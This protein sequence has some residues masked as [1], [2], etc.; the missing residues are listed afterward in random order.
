MKK[1]II[2]FMLLIIPTIF[3]V[4]QEQSNIQG[5][6]SYSLDLFPGTSISEWKTGQ[7][8]GLDLSWQATKNTSFDSK[9]KLSSNED[10]NQ[11]KPDFFIENLFVSLVP[12][13]W[14][15]L[16][17]GIFQY[18]H[19]TAKLLPVLNNEFSK[20]RWI[21][22]NSSELIKGIFGMKAN[23]IFNDLASLSLVIDPQPSLLQTNASALL[24][25]LLND[26][27]ISIGVSAYNYELL[28]FHKIDDDLKTSSHQEKRLAA[29]LSLSYYHENFGLYGDVIV[30]NG[31]SRQ[32][33]DVSQG[34]IYGSQEQAN[35]W[36]VTTTV[37]FE[38]LLKLKSY[39]SSTLLLEYKF[40]QNTL[41][42]KLYES[43]QSTPQ[44]D[45]STILFV[46][47]SMSILDSHTI[48]FGFSNLPI[49]KQLD[50]DLSARYGFRTQLLGGFLN[51]HLAMP[52]NKTLNFT[53]GG[54]T[55]IRSDSDLLID[56]LFGRQ[57]MFGLQY[58]IFY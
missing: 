26:F 41:N 3:L 14:F 37:G 22:Q 52:E 7:A 8:I 5:N 40:N 1:A 34:I 54:S 51:L 36:F 46:D 10:L 31:D 47:N 15:S 11:I 27:E 44:Q 24:D 21:E 49:H 45:S 4:S 19:G 42:D 39:S 28:S 56:R 29:S 12:S 35:N 57:L 50:L 48:A 58:T 55:L 18:S 32:W 30:D 20:H 43:L 2:R 16:D 38:Y 6:I 23:F 17:A 53:I 13:F 33:A 9:I 25:L